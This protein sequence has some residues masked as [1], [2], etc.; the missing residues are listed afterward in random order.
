[1][2]K[3]LIAVVGI[4]LLLTGCSSEPEPT[5]TATPETTAASTEPAASPES[6]F[7]TEF[8]STNPDADRGTDEQ[9]L[10]L[11]QSICDALEAGA[12]PN[13]I[14]D[15]LQDGNADADEAASAIVLAA[16]HLC[17]EFG[18]GN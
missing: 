15:S 2:G 7:L 18:V 16:E 10:N 13:Q 3:K 11:G 9:W 12:S 5:A 1:M 17:P 14:V 6:A 8:R 4:A